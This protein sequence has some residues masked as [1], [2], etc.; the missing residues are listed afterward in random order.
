MA[1]SNFELIGGPEELDTID[2][3]ALVLYPAVA[4][5]ILGVFSFTIDVFDDFALTDIAW[6]IGGYDITWAMI[7]AV[8]AIAWIVA[9]NEIDGSDYEQWEY[10]VIVFSFLVVPLY[11]FVPQFAGF[12]DGNPW[13]A[14]GLWL[15]A[16]AA[17]VY[18]S[19]TE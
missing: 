10:G 7:L 11:E 5:M 13:L 4:G 8:A 6:T 2:Y 1:I 12:I 18:V 14:F 19:Y 15:L 16:S 9:T 17:A 3:V